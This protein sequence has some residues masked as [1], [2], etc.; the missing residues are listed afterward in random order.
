[1]PHHTLNID[2]V[3]NLPPISHLL[4][5]R[6]DRSGSKTLSIEIDLNDPQLP[7]FVVV[8]KPMWAPPQTYTYEDLTEAVKKYN[9]IE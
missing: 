5:F 1:M 3:R 8:L 9:D 4:A 2:K 7:D 6:S